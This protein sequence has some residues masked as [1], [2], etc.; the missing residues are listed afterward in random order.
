MIYIILIANVF[1]VIKYKWKYFNYNNHK[2]DFYLSIIFSLLLTGVHKIETVSGNGLYNIKM[3]F[4]I[5][6][7]EKY[8]SE[9]ELF[10]IV[11]YFAISDAAYRI[12]LFIINVVMLYCFIV[13]FRTIFNKEK[14]TA[15]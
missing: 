9:N 6:W 14:I 4:P 2:I 15:E 11:N 12:E 1:F 13:G 10:E 8:V 5:A 7:I 3:G